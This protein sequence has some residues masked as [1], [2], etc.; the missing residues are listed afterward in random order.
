MAPAFGTLGLQ[1]A[2]DK[3][4]VTARKNVAYLVSRSNA[5]GVAAAEGGRWGGG[6]G[7]EGCVKAEGTHSRTSFMAEGDKGDPRLAVKGMSGAGRRGMNIGRMPGARGH[8]TVMAGREDPRLVV[9]I[10]AA[11]ARG[12][13]FVC[14][15]VKFTCTQPSASQMPAK[16]R[17]PAATRQRNA[18]TRELITVT[19]QSQRPKSRRPFAWPASSAHVPPQRELVE[20]Q[21]SKWV[22]RNGLAPVRRRCQSVPASVLSPLQVP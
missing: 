19:D 17:L 6:H 14:V 4:D 8:D 20:T 10:R 21:V 2:I 15:L 18:Q 22:L 16:S 12:F 13:D 7:V 9:E 1:V 5:F 11:I 3:I